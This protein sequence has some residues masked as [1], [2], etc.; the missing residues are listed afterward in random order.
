M[1]SSSSTVKSGKGKKRKAKEIPYDQIQV[2]LSYPNAEESKIDPVSR[3][4]LLLAVISKQT[5]QDFNQDMLN[6]DTKRTR[7]ELRQE[8]IFV[9]PTKTQRLYIPVRLCSTSQSQSH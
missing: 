7:K 4:P 9:T 5:N 6:M 8:T 1:S 2:E 3:G